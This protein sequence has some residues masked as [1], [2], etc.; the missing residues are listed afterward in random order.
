MSQIDFNHVKHRVSF[1]QAVHMLGLSLTKGETEIE[2][3]K[4]TQFRGPCPRC[5]TGG[6]RALTVTPG[7][8]FCC[9]ATK[10]N[11]RF[12]RGDVIAFV[13]HVRGLTFRQAAEE[14]LRYAGENG[15]QPAAAAMQN[16]VDAL[17]KV[18]D[19]LVYEHEDVQAM[20]LTPDQAKKL[21]IGYKPKG[22]F[23]GKV[24][25]PLFVEGKI[26]S[27]CAVDGAEF[28]KNLSL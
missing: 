5:L 27:Y 2:G 14:L 23:R 24:V 26:V 21:G 17:Q 8:G 7:K 12:P 25:L 6:A 10:E 3:E 1:A 18:R 16:V 19:Y 20:G 15:P 9:F 28:P 4:W 11:G 22:L 13:A